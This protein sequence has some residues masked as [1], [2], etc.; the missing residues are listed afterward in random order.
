MRSEIKHKIEVSS[1]KQVDL[2]NMD[3]NDAEIG[4]I[5]SLIVQ[6]R[7]KIKELFLDHNL[8]TDEG[9]KMLANRLA[10]LQELAELSLQSNRI[11]RSG[12]RDIYCL[13]TTHPKLMFFLHGNKV[14]DVGEIQVIKDDV[15]AGIK[16]AASNKVKENSLSSHPKKKWWSPFHHSGQKT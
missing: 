13:L 9:A 11:D 16:E 6:T 2:E 1:T 5:A 8:L 12:I 10:E 3:I 15:L 4:E 14:R 7:P